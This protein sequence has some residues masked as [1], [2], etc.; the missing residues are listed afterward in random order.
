MPLLDL[1]LEKKGDFPYLDIF[2]FALFM[3]CLK[4]ELAWQYQKRA[5]AEVC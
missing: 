2:S 1:S 4:G 3:Y 5:L